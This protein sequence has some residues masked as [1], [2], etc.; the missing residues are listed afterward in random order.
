M[1]YLNKHSIKDTKTYP[2]T[3][4]N[5]YFNNPIY[6]PMP[7][8]FDANLNNLIRKEIDNIDNWPGIYQFPHENVINLLIK[9]V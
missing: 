1:T 6:E 7:Q 9:L 2:Y 3:C 5:K 8:I 4:M